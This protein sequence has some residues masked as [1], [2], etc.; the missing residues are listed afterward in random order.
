MHVFQPC[1]LFIVFKADRAEPLEASSKNRGTKT[2]LRLLS[3]ADPSVYVC[4]S[5]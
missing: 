4:V 5:L 1:V 2:G 3:S